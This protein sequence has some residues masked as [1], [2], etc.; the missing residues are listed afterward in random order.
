MNQTALVILGMVALFIGASLASRYRFARATRQV[1]L[2]FSKINAFDAENSVK[3]EDVGM[4][5][6]NVF[7]RWGMRDYK[8]TAFQCLVQ[9]KVIEVVETEEGNKY[10]LPKEHYDKYVLKK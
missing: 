10:Y 7:L 2:I 5:Q 1:M 4:I 6:K 3:A 9:A 8:I